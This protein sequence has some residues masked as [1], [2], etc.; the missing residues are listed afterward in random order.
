MRPSFAAGSVARPAVETATPAAD[1]GLVTYPRASFGPSRPR[2]HA[3]GAVLAVLVAV[4]LLSPGPLT[5]APSRVLVDAASL[6]TIWPAAEGGLAAAP[7]AGTPGPAAD[8]GQSLAAAAVGP[9]EAPSQMYEDAQ[10]H[11]GQH[12]AFTPGSRVTIPFAP[13]ARDGLPVGGRAPHALAAGRLSGVEMDAQA[14]RAGAP[15]PGPGTSPI[16]APIDAPASTVVPVPAVGTSW[17]ASPA[18]QPAAPAAATGLRRQVYGFLPYWEVGASTTRLNFS[19][20]SHVAYFSVGADAAGNLLKRTSTGSLTTG[21][22]GWT[23]AAMTT[24]INAAHRAHSRVTLTIS[25]FA[26]TSGQARLQA[27]LLGSAAARAN[28]AKQAVAAVRDRGAD[29]INLDFE[30]LVSGSEAGFVAL[31]KAIRAEFNRIGPGYHLSFDTMG[32]PGNYPLEAAL[33]PGVADAVFIMGY[34][35]RQAGST[36]AASIDPLSGPAYDLTETVQAYAARVPRSKVILGIPYY[37]RAWSTVAGTLNAKTQTGAKYGASTAVIYLDAVPLASKYGRSYDGRE[38]SAWVAYQKQSCTT[39]YGCVTTWRQLYY[40]DAATLKARYDMVNRAGIAGVGIWA[41]GYDGSRTELY[42]ALADKFL[43]DTTPPLAGITILPA[44]QRDEGFVVRWSGIDDWNGI[45]GYDVQVSVDGGPWANWKT[46][47]TATNDVWLGADGHGYAFRVRARDGKGNLGVYAVTSV[48][49]PPRLAAG[50]FGQVVAPT[51]NVRSAPTVTAAR[52]DTALA[53][54]ILAITGGPVS[55][56][57]YAWYRVNGPIASW[58]PTGYVRSDAWVAASGGG[59][60]LLAPALA[61]NGTV[62]SAGIRHVAFSGLTSADSLGTSAPALAARSFSPNGDAS[63]DVL[64]LSWD[65]QRAFASMTLRVLRADGT[66]AGSIALANVAAGAQRTAWDGK[67]GGTRVPDGRYLLQLVASAGT[68]TWTWPSAAPATAAQV[69]AVGALVDTIPPVLAS[70]TISGSRISPNGDGRLDT[71]AIKGTATGGAARWTLAVAPFGGAAVRRI[72]GAG[73]AAS[74]AWDGRGDNGS[75]V[76]DGSYVLTL[77]FF[78][79]A[80][81]VAAR[82]WTVTV[83]RTAAVL[84]LAVAPSAFSPNGDGTVDTTRLAWTASEAVTGT[85]RVWRGTTLVASWA[86]ART[87]GAATWN[88]R[89]RLGLLVPDGRYTVTLD[90]LDGTGNRSTRS[91]TALVDR[92]AGFLRWSPGA[93][94]P[95]D[96]DAILRTSVASFR[97]TRTARTSLVI[98]D[99]GGHPVRTAWTGR[100]RAAGTWTWAWDGRTG[101]GAMAPQGAYVAQLTVVGP[102]GATVLRRTILAAAFRVVAATPAIAGATYG[103]TFRSV[104]PLSTVPVVTFRQ[105]GR[106]AARMTVVHLADGSWRATIKVATGAPGPA[107]V[108]IKG[109]DTGG[110]LNT[111]AVSTVV[112]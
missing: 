97:L 82:S 94:F 43:T 62:V 18:A 79:A 47:T 95:Q 73:G 4:T 41:L 44:T 3:H 16:P 89:N 17:I 39:T 112:P 30:P 98:L 25:V 80:G 72:G 13:D 45:A 74:I 58:G 37:G 76:P 28:L 87:G 75:V 48:T 11:A 54:E 14:I 33:A 108:T 29:G 99:A 88:G 85:L 55:A 69:A 56:D 63:E 21:W 26:W 46:S 101:T 70:A 50:G 71:L 51:L 83:D 10:A 66:L 1:E 60:T 86:A 36:V 32:Q 52:L 92:T 68:T 104:E 24:T 106:S 77:R 34:D 22:A 49:S 2:R 105:A 93:F 107:T 12:Y 100:S 64:P 19:V 42:Q 57:G 59:A 109:R 84:G 110:R 7:V 78:D 91:A 67:V 111:F 81:N 31:L 20:L 23:S 53:G 38:V 65:N 6:A 8:A 35:Y 102:Y 96:G 61:P 5:A 15:A 40:D 9:G 27:A 103:L 90:V